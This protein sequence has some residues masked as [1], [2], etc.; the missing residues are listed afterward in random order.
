M[1]NKNGQKLIN[2]N[3][4]NI[5]TTGTNAWAGVQLMAITSSN[6]LFAVDNT[7]VNTAYAFYS[8]AS[9]GIYTDALVQAMTKFSLIGFHG[10]FASGSISATTNTKDRGVRWHCGH[11]TNGIF[12]ESTYTPVDD[13]N[14]YVS[15]SQSYG[16]KTFTV[17]NSTSSPLTI[18]EL[19]FSAY[20]QKGASTASPAEI[21]F[22]GFNLGEIT[23]PAGGAASFTLTHLMESENT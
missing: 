1:F 11:R 13:A 20:V 8:S 18:N 3:Y 12:S 19:S 15:F 2:T 6:P 9:G 17:T 22:A 16:V 10:T 23:I 4:G 5:Q 14:A 21:L 7:Q